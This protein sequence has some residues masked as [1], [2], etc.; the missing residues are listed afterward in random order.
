MTATFPAGLSCG[1]TLKNSQMKYFLHFFFFVAMA[2][3]AGA[4]TLFSLSPQTVTAEKPAD[5]F[6]MYSYA[7]FENLSGTDLN[8]RW[9]RTL[10]APQPLNGHGIEWGEWSITLQ[11]PTAW[12]NPA[13]DLDSADFVL[14]A[15]PEES[16]NKFIMQFYPANEPGHLIVKYKVFVIDNPSESVEIT[17][18]YTASVVSATASEVMMEQLILSSNP[19]N[20]AVA[21]SNPFELPGTLTITNSTGK[22]FLTKKL[23]GKDSLEIP[24]GTWPAGT[25]QVLFQSTGKVYVTRLVVMH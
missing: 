9:V 5:F 8:M 3:Q 7:T 25:Y 12:H 13:T 4:Q 16:N 2:F 1:L 20:T 6:T 24:T 22:Q 11:D 17:F 21:V 15:I 19:A 14:A 23:E 10:A 18:D